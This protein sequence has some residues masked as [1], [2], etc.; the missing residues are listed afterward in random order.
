MGE[1]NFPFLFVFRG[2]AR[3]WDKANQCRKRK[4]KSKR[5]YS[6]L[7]EISKR[8][9]SDWDEHVRDDLKKHVDIRREGIEGTE[10]RGDENRRIKIIRYNENKDCAEIRRENEEINGARYSVQRLG[11]AKTNVRLI[12]QE[13]CWGQY[14]SSMRR[15]GDN[16]RKMANF[17]PSNSP[18]YSFVFWCRIENSSRWQTL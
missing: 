9:G 7:K 14:G 1:L 10:S 3:Y 12:Q 16:L 5:L 6:Y 2:G 4:G 11:K 15:K 8:R 13:Y 17:F 18:F